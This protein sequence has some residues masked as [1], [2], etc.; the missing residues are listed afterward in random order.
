MRVR[1]GSDA[2]PG[3]LPPARRARLVA[4]QIRAES[5]SASGTA[6]IRHSWPRGR[7]PAAAAAR[8]IHVR[9]ED[10][11]WDDPARTLL[12]RFG[13]IQSRVESFRE[14]SCPLNCSDAFSYARFSL[15][16]LA[17]RT[18]QRQQ[19]PKTFLTGSSPRGPVQVLGSARKGW[20]IGGRATRSR[21]R[22]GWQPH[23]MTGMPTAAAMRPASSSKAL[24]MPRAD[25]TEPWPTTAGLAKAET[26][27]RA[28]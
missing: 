28:R 6:N 5:R 21:P 12:E 19:S 26:A 10:S 4:P 25:P 14:T 27:A 3:S 8:Q 15:P 17:R 11:A 18:A 22:E 23:V 2:R 1:S 16:L 7:Q 13:R 20:T 9:P 24:A